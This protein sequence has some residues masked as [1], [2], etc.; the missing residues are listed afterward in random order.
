MNMASQPIK[1]PMDPTDIPVIDLGMTTEEIDA[2]YGGDD[3][4]EKPTTQ[5]NRLS[6]SLQKKPSKLSTQTETAR[7]VL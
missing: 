4:P 3:Q 6:I 1:L 7:L 2:I 5:R